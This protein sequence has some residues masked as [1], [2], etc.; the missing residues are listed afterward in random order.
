V[1]RAA[2]RVLTAAIAA[3][4]TIA[5]LR[6]A[7]PRSAAPAPLATNID[8]ASIARAIALGRSPDRSARQQFHDA[9]FIRLN[10]PLLDQL[11]IVTEFRRVVLVTEDRAGAADSDWGPRQAADMLRPW[12]GRFALVL[13][14]TFPPTNTYRAMPRF[15]IVLYGRPPT[16]A[17]ARIDPLEVMETPRYVSGQPAPPGTPI[18]AGLVEATFGAGRIDPRAIYLAGIA[19]EG[20]ELRRVEVDFGRIE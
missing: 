12:R 11:E 1:T 14:V 3:L 13:H 16:A 8:A 18:L 7:A 5:G 15:D 4:L 19:F 20:R 17:P 6:A 9:Y 2:I 10:D